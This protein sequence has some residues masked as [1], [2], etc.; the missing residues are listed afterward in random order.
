MLIKIKLVLAAALTLGTASAALANSDNW[1]DVGGYVVPGST[2]GVNPV[3][4]PRWFPE[5]GRV[6]RSYDRANTAIYSGAGA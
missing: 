4:H 6:M 1:N 2:A 3:Y 5:Y